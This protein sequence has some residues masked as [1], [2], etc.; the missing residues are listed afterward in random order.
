M[1]IKELNDYCLEHDKY[2]VVD[3]GKLKGFLSSSKE[4]WLG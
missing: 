4:R 3:R 2:I 1:N